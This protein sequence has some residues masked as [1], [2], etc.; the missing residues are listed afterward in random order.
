MLL[1]MGQRINIKHHF[2]CLVM[3]SVFVIELTLYLDVL[4]YSHTDEKS[5]PWIQ[6]IHRMLIFEDR[7]IDDVESALED[8]LQH[9]DLSPAVSNCCL[10]VMFVCI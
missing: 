10:A 5:N 4:C 2:Q 8:I 1:I 6:L 3:F 9:K 7:N